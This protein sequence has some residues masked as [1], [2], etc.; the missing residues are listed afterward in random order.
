ML[1]VISCDSEKWD[2]YFIRGEIPAA[3]QSTVSDE[4]PYHNL[5]EEKTMMWFCEMSICVGLT[6]ASQE[7]SVSSL[8]CVLLCVCVVDCSGSKKCKLQ[9]SFYVIVQ[10]DTLKLAF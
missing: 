2:E 6:C 10:W 9:V 3:N 1:G 4:E 7:G 8:L 5:P